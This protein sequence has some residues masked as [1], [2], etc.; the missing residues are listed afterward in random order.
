MPPRSKVAQLPDEVRQE[1]DRRLIADGFG[2]YVALSEWL[3]E[4]GFS[5]GKSALAEHGAQLGRR[6]EAVRLA[7]E[8][9]EAL[10]AAAPDDAG[11]VADAS[12]RLAQ[13]RIFQVLVAAEGGDLKE[14]AGA[15]RALAETARAG[16]AI[17]AERR[18]ALAEAVERAGKAARKAGLSADATAAI[19]AAIEGQAAA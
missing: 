10:V 7:T 14:L 6:I 15:A 4:R 1:L 18:K 19:R 12:I 11:A 17:R 2:G 3:A 13:E 9:A 16:T 8:Q 5:I